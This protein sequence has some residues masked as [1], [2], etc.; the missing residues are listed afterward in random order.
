MYVKCPRDTLTFFYSGW[1]INILL[2]YLGSSKQ[3]RWGLVR[4]NIYF[5]TQEILVWSSNHPYRN[6]KKRW[7]LSWKILIEWSWSR[8]SCRCPFSMIGLNHTWVSLSCT[9]WR[10]DYVHRGV[11][12]IIYLGDCAVSVQSGEVLCSRSVGRG[13]YSRWLGEGCFWEPVTVDIKCEGK[14]TVYYFP[15]VVRRSVI[16]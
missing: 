12:D 1:S 5:Y 11:M 8:G 2:V 14:E 13:N 15:V 3:L 16:Y 9:G 4:C 7:K 6:F 10:L